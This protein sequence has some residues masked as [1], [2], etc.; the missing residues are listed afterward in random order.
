MEAGYTCCT[1]GELLVNN[2]RCSQYSLVPSQNRT[3]SVTP[4]M[5]MRAGVMQL[6]LVS[7]YY[8][9]RTAQVG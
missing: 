6:G 4:Y 9:A 7:I 3:N 2:G 8:P 5:H 1:R